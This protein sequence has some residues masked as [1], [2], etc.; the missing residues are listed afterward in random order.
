MT[1][2]EVFNSVFD[3]SLLI[4]TDLSR[5][6]WPV[7]VDYKMGNGW[8]STQYCAANA[9]HRQEELFKIGAELLASA[10]EVQYD[11]HDYFYEER[12]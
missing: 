3:E 12:H 9:M 11:S 10:C 1:T 4:R 2:L 8:E 6:E 5:P 7:E